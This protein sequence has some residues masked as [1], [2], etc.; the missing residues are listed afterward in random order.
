MSAT[1]PPA[2]SLSRILGFGFSIALA[3]GGTIGVGIL[4][5]PGTVAAA[6]GDVRLIILVWVIGGVYAL[7]GAVS[8]A[9]LASALPKAG[10]F[11]VYAR[12]AFG[13]TT[14]FVVGLN[15]WLLNSLTI[16]YA[17]ATAAEFFIVLVP[18]Y[19]P[20][21]RWLAIGVVLAF[22]A[23][24]WIG[25]RIGSTVQNT[26]SALVG[27]LLVGLALGSLTLTGTPVAGALPPAPISIASLPLLSVG[28]VAAL[29]AAL[30]SVVVTY[31]GWYTAIYLAEETVDA[32]RA[33]P[34]AM[35]GC[36]LL[37]TALYLLINIGFVHAL[38]LPVLAASKLPAADVARQLFPHGGAEFVTIVSLCTVL[39]LINAILLGAPRI[40]YAVGRDLSIGA[41]ASV[42]EGGTPRVA[43]A[44]TSVAALL[45]ILWGSLEE[46]IA[47]AAVLFVMNY[48]AGYLALF[49]L[50]WREPGLERP[51]RALGYPWA[52]AIVLLGSVAFLFA[53]LADDPRS[54]WFAVR[55]VLVAAVLG[56]WLNRRGAAAGN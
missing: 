21:G 41:V 10:G 19:A 16:S 40:F 9:E 27:M 35:I 39:G 50:R 12:R 54:G 52:A 47:L 4:R 14:G 34:R 36:A 25:I 53:A 30:R 29:A 37:V 33:V 11:Y 7:L 2:P 5:L 26:I 42:S 3:F 31:D 32:S 48:V 15:D 28:M 13:P 44:F 56:W 8:L 23:L 1:S 49:T 20:H 6:L 17:A 46:L 24:H 43:L 55:M 18:A 38:S 51:F 45:L 22:T